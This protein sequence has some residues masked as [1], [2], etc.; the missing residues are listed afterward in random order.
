MTTQHDHESHPG[1]LYSSR[2]AFIYLFN[3]VLGSG[4]LALPSILTQGGWVLGSGFLVVVTFFSY[5]SLTFVVETMASANALLAYRKEERLLEE[6]GESDPE[7]VR[8]G[9]PDDPFQIRLRTEFGRMAELFFS[10][11]GLVLFYVALIAYLYGSAAI[12]ASFVP[13][14]ILQVVYN[15]SG[16]WPFWSYN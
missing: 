10:T 3:L 11:P 12:F 9:L 15:S 8:E 2:I 14:S 16:P 4:V 5:V 1:E 6:A 13:A 7:S